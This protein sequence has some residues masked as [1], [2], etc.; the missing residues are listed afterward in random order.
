MP[1]VLQHC[2]QDSPLPPAY[3]S[4]FPKIN[5]LIQQLDLASVVSHIGDMCKTESVADVIGVEPRALRDLTR[6][7][8]TWITSP[9]SK[10]RFIN[11]G[12]PIWQSSRGLVAS[13]KRFCREISQILRGRRNCWTCL[14]LQNLPKFFSRASW[15]F[16]HKRSRRLC[17]ACYRHFFNDDGPTDA[18]K[19]KR[20]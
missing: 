5:R 2:C 11:S 15:E 7:S 6:C 17:K 20:G 19:Y 18:T 9:R 16:R 14:F 13:L 10:R 8:P 12:L 3:L 4:E 1:V